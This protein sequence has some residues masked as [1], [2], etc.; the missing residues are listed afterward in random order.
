ME[1]PISEYMLL[2]RGTDWGKDLS[3][4]EIQ[5]VMGQFNHWMEQLGQHGKLKTG[6][7][8]A[9]MGKIVSGKNVRTVADG[10][11]AESKEAIGGYWLLRVESFDEAVSIAEDCPLLN[12]GASIEVRPVLEKCAEM[13]WLD[14]HPAEV[15]ELSYEQVSG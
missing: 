12:Y 14:E 4:R 6:Q 2:F 10:P 15:A 13:Q 5:N 8:L 11:F 7:P 1:S 3:P 9:P